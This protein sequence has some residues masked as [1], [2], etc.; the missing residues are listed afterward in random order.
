[1]KK[2]VWICYMMGRALLSWAETREISLALGKQ[3]GRKQI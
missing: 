1:M 3:A 2:K